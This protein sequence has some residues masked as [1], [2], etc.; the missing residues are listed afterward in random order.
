MDNV[1][2]G[3]SIR[4]SGVTP[5]PQG[6]NQPVEQNAGFNMAE[7]VKKISQRSKIN[8]QTLQALKLEK[9]LHRLSSEYNKTNSFERKSAIISEM[10]KIMQEL[11]KL[12]S[13]DK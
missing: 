4:N 8:R 3:D 11:Q 13:E 12:E 2:A 5:Q 1:N 6:N 10:A 7:Q 9:K